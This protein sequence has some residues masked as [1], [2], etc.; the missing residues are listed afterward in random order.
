M[1]RSVR[2]MTRPPMRIF[3][4]YQVNVKQDEDDSS[5]SSNSS[6]NSITVDTGFVD[7]WM[8]ALTD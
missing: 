5:I 2:D 4:R 6:S 1:R 8:Y 3:I 7:A